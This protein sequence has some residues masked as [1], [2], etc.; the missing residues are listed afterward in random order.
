MSLQYNYVFIYSLWF[1]TAAFTYPQ[2]SHSIW[3]SCSADLPNASLSR[4]AFPALDS[5]LCC[6]TIIPLK[7][8]RVIKLAE[9]L[10]PIFQFF[11]IDCVV[12]MKTRCKRTAFCVAILRAAYITYPLIVIQRPSSVD[13]YYA[14]TLLWT[15][16]SDKVLRTVFVKGLN[17]HEQQIQTWRQVFITEW[18]SRWNVY[19]DNTRMFTTPEKGSSIVIKNKITFSM[20]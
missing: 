14:F 7:K 5:E 11:E 19:S 2:Y 15:R 16:K 1:S 13:I 17:I 18:M 8:Y 12:S 20:H 4:N 9:M 6:N 10:L 3:S